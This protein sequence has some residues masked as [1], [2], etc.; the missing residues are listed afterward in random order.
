[1]LQPPPL[2]PSD[3]ISRVVVRSS[4]G[5]AW[6]GYGAELFTV[7]VGLHAIAARPHHRVAVHVG[8]AVKASWPT[9]P[10]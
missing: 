5:R 1:M 4:M 8:A 2:P 9:S 6:N 7:S 10:P 3:T